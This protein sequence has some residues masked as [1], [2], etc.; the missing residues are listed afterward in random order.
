MTSTVGAVSYTQQKLPTSDLVESLVVGGS[1]KKK[2]Y[3]N[4]EDV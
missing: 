3:V 4:I 1:C 2:K